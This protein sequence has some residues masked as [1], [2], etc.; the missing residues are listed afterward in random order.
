MVLKNYHS[1]VALQGIKISDDNNN[2]RQIVDNVSI[3][4][5][6]NFDGDDKYYWN[7]D[8]DFI[9]LEP[10]PEPEPK[11]DGILF[12]HTIEVCSPLFKKNQES[13]ALFYIE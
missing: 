3:D 13:N 7:L 9:E 2:F 6:K 8:T 4:G 10:E 5:I 11:I 1:N 12:Y